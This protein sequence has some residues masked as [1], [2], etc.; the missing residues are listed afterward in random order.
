MKKNIVKKLMAQPGEKHKISDYDHAY[1]A[2][3]SKNDA[4]DKMKDTIKKL[5]KLQNKLYAFDKYTVLIIF[6]AMDAAGKDG[7]IKH[8]MSGINPQGCQVFSFKQPSYEELDHDYLWR[9]YKNLPEKG[10]IGIFNRSHYEE[11]IITKVHPELILNQK[12]PDIK[13]IKDVDGEFWK[14]RYRQ[15]ND[16]ERHLTENGVLILKFFLN[17]SR[18]EQEKR[19][20]ARLEDE[21]KNWKFSLS[22]LKERAFWNEYMKAYSDMLTETSTENAPWYVI[23][24]DNKWFMRYAVADIICDKIEELNIDYPELTKKAKQDLEKAKGMINDHL[25]ES[26]S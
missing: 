25:S 3:I 12:N 18:N 11:V 10:R 23:P 13:T 15:I 26:E 5:R 16:F 14:K 17:V 21:T 19:F 22:D 7:T 1:T 20:L 9:I 8:V 24:A 4:E 2:D 6:Q